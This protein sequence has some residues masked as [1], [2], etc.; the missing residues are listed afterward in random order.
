MLHNQLINCRSS[1]TSSRR[2][3]PSMQPAEMAISY[4]TSSGRGGRHS[5]CK[6]MTTSVIARGSG[7]PRGWREPP[8]RW[9]RGTRRMAGECRTRNGNPALTCKSIAE[10]KTLLPRACSVEH[11]SLQSIL[12][13]PGSLERSNSD[14]RAAL[15]PTGRNHATSHNAGAATQPRTLCRLQ[16]AAGQSNA[17]ILRICLHGCFLLLR[18]SRDH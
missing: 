17:G 18:D 15:I 2:P 8:L 7:A 11:A 1:S 12:A 13:H 16:P 5:G 4:P 9:C 10:V 14:R 3:G 6:A